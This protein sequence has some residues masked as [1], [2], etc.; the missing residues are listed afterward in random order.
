MKTKQKSKTSSDCIKLGCWNIQGLYSKSA[1]KTIDDDFLHEINGIDILALVETHVVEGQSDVPEI[2]GYA[3]K[4]F[5]RPKHSKAKHGSGGIAILYNPDLKDGLKFYP[6]KGNDYIWIKLDKNFY[7]QSEHIYIC[8]AYIP[9]TNSSYTKRIDIN[10]LDNIESDIYKYKQQG[11]I[12]LLGDLNG[13]VGT[14]PDYIT[15][16]NDQHLPFQDNYVIDNMHR[17]RISQDTKVDDRGKHILEICIAGQLRLLNGRTI[18]DTMGHFTSHQYHGSSVI[19]YA[20][21]S[22]ELTQ[23][24]TYFKVHEFIGTISDHC[25]LSLMLTTSVAYNKDIEKEIPLMSFPKQFKWNDNTKEVYQ[26]TLKLPPVQEALAKAQTSIAN[27][28]DRS[29][30]NIATNVLTSALCDAASLS[31]K[32]KLWGKHKKHKPPWSSG[33]IVRL[34]HE[35]KTKGKNMVKLQTGEARC[36]YFLTLKRLRKEKK[37]ARRH[38]MKNQME[39]LNSLKTSNPRQFWQTLQQLNDG[40]RD[41]CAD[42]IAPGTWYNYLTRNNKAAATHEENTKLS[43]LIN[44]ENIG[45]NELDVSISEDELKEA[46]HKL[47]NNKSPGLDRVLNE[48][49]KY[50]DD[51]THKIML[52]LFNKIYSLSMYPSS[53]SHG[54]ITNL[55]KK[56][57]TMDPQNYRSLTI[58]S[59]LG[60]LFNSILATRLQK[61]LTE[62][63]LIAREQ[64]GFMKETSTSDHVFS[65]H[66]L[67]NK[68]ANK[69]SQKLYACFVDFRKA[70]DSVWHHGLFYKLAKLNINNHLLRII[71]DMYADNQLCIKVQDK[72]SNFFTSLKGVRQGDNLSPTLFNIF[73]NDLPAYIGNQSNT[74][75]VCLGNQTF[76]CL[77]YADDVILLSTSPIGLQN[78]LKGLETFTEEWKLDLNLNKTKVLIFNKSGKHLDEPF[79][80]NNNYIECTAN[81]T[82]LGINFDNSGNL[83]NAVQELYKKGLKAV[84]KLY[85]LTGQ[86]YDFK[87]LLHIF[88][89]T[90]API[91]LYAS[92]VWGIEFAKIGKNNNSNFRFEKQ[93][94]GN[95]MTTLEMKFYRHLLHVKRNTATLAIRGELGRYPLTINAI[96]RSIKY[97]HRISQSP[98][99]SIIKQALEESKLLDSKGCTSWFT[100]V[101]STLT[102]FKIPQPPPA[103]TKYARKQ[104]KKTTENILRIIYEEYWAKEI[105]T[106]TSKQKNKGGNK[107]RTYNKLKQNFSFET[108]L[109]AIDDIQHRSA[110]TKLRI[111]SHTLN[112]ENLRGKV[113]NPKERLC[114]LCNL[115]EVED[116]IHFLTRCPK[117][118]L[119]RGPMKREVT[120]SF[121]NMSQ[122]TD[123]N[124][125]IWLLTNEDKQ[126]CKKVGKYIFECFDIRKSENN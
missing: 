2:P 53:W 87:T 31:M 30:I 121:P 81:Y 38:F 82:Y 120:N 34:E 68:Y 118:S 124:L 73:I 37:Y 79:T 112:I 72:I 91:L 16:D 102:T 113:T 74:H 116:E 85:K 45:F 50:S 109:T 1:D 94:E 115:Q 66:T 56:G 28:T 103:P 111:S 83:K 44:T 105:N 8:A 3:T 39:K 42:K 63:N 21:C 20:I 57:S 55:F 99:N 22:S 43:E 59:S 126:T 9:P 12:I 11:H 25:M 52:S 69:K 67:I 97:Y 26:A 46:I 49:I 75:P 58:T 88:D 71:K 117:Y 119:L 41:N 77:M 114:T 6:S 18:G 35:V 106:T 64:I 32:N 65:L 47:K 92:E 29:S 27:C 4:Y 98:N 80:F 70:F 51:N 78:C 19:D 100:K 76:N 84:F 54:Y 10:I 101:N 108:Y 123:E 122:I 125:T 95:P 89:H 33:K 36:N 60:K 90:V 5:N 17:P 61:Y 13:R 107:L 15:N 48:M 104:Y 23:Q 62:H 110:F 96:S 93:L 24:V 40:K 86:S 14:L 7:N